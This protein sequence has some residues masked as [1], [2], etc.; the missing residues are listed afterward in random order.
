[1]YRYEH[2]SR[3]NIGKRT[4]AKTENKKDSGYNGHFKALEGLIYV[5]EF[6]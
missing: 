5:F 4:K 3:Q 1:M 2:E 6:V